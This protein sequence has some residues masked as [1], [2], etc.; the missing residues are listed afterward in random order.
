MAEWSGSGE[1]SPV[2]PC[3]EKRRRLISRRSK[4]ARLFIL[5]GGIGMRL[6]KVTSI[7]E[8]IALIGQNFAPLDSEAVSLLAAGGRICA[9]TVVAR[10]DTP[11]FD[12]ST[13]DG[14]AVKAAETF[15][16]QESI[17]G[18]FRLVGE[19]PMGGE[20]PPI[21]SG[22]CCYVPTGGMLPEGS[23]AVVMVEYTEVSGTMVHILRQAAPHE[24]IIR[25]GEDL[26]AGAIVLQ[27]G[28]K[29]RGPE[30]GLL[31][32]LGQMTVQVY[33]RPVIG[34]VSSGDELVPPE[35]EELVP[36][37][38]RD[39]NRLALRHLA[40]Q[41]GMIVVDRGILPDE[42]AAFF[43]AVQSLLDCCDFI[44]LSGGSSMGNKD[45]T[46]KVLQRL[47]GG[48]LLVEGLAVQPGKPTLLA[49]CEGKP[50]LGLPGHPVSALNIFSLIG[51]A[52]CRRLSGAPE[53]IWRP[54]IKATLSRNIPSRPGRIDMV[55][56]VLGLTSEGT[57]ATP[58]FGRSGLL[59]TLAD[60]DGIVWVASESDGLSA[61]ETV[62]VYLWE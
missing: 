8:A 12:R 38:I 57:V 55:R 34:I 21:A 61:G 53:K 6:L 19:V 7:E 30:L 20:A 41:M 49:S 1:K 28:R 13:V 24:N 50:V 16:A 35:T 60:A 26:R 25:R 32:S 59:R 47:S 18:L 52:V 29:L 4:R 22:E 11:A 46:A 2:L 36:G 31:A 43:N 37:R 14:Y 56:V 10:E 48:E 17:P 9:E 23:D 3:L 58:V 5:V 44:A 40:E 62:E 54:S 39:A 42:E 51:G 27:T 45:Y 33:R 15:G